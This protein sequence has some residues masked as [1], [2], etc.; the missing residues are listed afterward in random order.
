MYVFCTVF[1][2]AGIGA[3]HQRLVAFKG[4]NGR[5]LGYSALTPSVIVAKAVCDGGEG[6]CGNL[7][8]RLDK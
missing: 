2:L 6:L 4:L 7:A 3:K 8:F 5:V 1:F